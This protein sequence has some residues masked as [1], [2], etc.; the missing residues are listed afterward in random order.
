MSKSVKIFRVRDEFAATVSSVSDLNYDFL[1]QRL[2]KFVEINT[3][4]L[5]LSESNDSWKRYDSLYPISG[6]NSQNNNNEYGLLI[7][8]SAISFKNYALIEFISPKVKCQAVIKIPC[9]TEGLKFYMKNANV[10]V[11][12]Y[13]NSRNSGAFYVTKAV[14]NAFSAQVGDKYTSSASGAE[15]ITYAGKVMGQ[16]YGGYVLL[17]DASTTLSGS[18]GTL[19][20][21]SSGTETAY[22]SCNYSV[23]RYKYSFYERLNKPVA[24]FEE[25]LSV[26]EDE[27][28]TITL[29]DYKFWEYDKLKL[30]IAKSGNFSIGAPSCKVIGGEDKIEKF[31]IPMPKQSGDAELCSETGFG[32]TEWNDVWTKESGIIFEQM[33]SEIRDYP[34]LNGMNSHVV[35][36]KKDDGFS[37]KISKTFTIPNSRGYRKMYIR[38]AA[39]LFPKIYNQ[40]TDNDYYTT[41]RQIT[42]TSDDYGHL[43]VAVAIEGSQTPA[44]FEAF[45]GCGWSE[46]FFEVLI[47]PFTTRVDVSVYRNP[48]DFEETEKLARTW[49][50]QVC[51]IS[52]SMHNM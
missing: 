2:R 12:P 33:P 18:A 16:E 6:Y 19:T 4:E 15:E 21:V 24:D 5:S 20:S 42:P 41:T 25:V 48:H 29:S 34:N 51:D 44:I 40:E 46:K 23:S 27:I 14:Y 38:V 3:G 9:A 13:S 43:N 47:S 28:Y 8:G 7:N 30:I 39:R 36:T 10:P 45:V 22:Q 50:M 31:T 32:T 37:N 35:L 49:P 1:N 26:Y 17:F 52:V 11:Q